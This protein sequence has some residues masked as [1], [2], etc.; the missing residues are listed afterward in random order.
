MFYLV[1]GSM[2]ETVPLP[3]IPGRYFV[4]IEGR[5]RAEGPHSLSFTTLGLVGL[6]DGALPAQTE[7][8][9]PSGY[10]VTVGYFLRIV[11]V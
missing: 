3:L 10:F 7:D 1:A 4:R 8:R 5:G 9:V 2:T 6:P 11:G